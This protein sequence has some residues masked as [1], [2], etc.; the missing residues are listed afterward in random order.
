MIRAVI[1]D[2]DGVIANSEPLHFTAFRGVLAE[3]GV[4]LTAEEYYAQY[5]GYDDIGVFRAVS[6]DRGLSWN[7]DLVTG[8]VDR[9]AV[10]L[11][12]L[13]QE[14]SI[15]FPGA[16]QAIRRLAATLPLAIA[17][18]ALRAEILRVLNHAG[19]S[20]YFRAVVAAEDTPASKPAPD[21]Y[22]RAVSLLGTAIGQP[23]APCECVA[24][25]DSQWGLE[26]ARAAGL[27]TIGITH[28]YPASS[29][30]AAEL[31]IGNLDAL[32]PATVRRFDQAL[33]NIPD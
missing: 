32:T 26:S 11:E 19:L 6:R 13:E 21:P 12:R 4:T 8:L 17:S 28:T 18:G 29:L 31:V 1:F 24:V 9:K 2:F 7:V 22:L 16:E 3:E 15:L 27:R 25:E 14:R 33:S 5:L 30:G 20:Q 23:L 10:R